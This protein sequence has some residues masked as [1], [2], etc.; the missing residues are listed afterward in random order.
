M[1]QSLPLSIK[2]MRLLHSM[3]KWPIT[4]IGHSIRACN[5]IRLH[6]QVLMDYTDMATK[7]PKGI[8]YDQAILSRSRT[9]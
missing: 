1:Q 7:P 3:A 5:N 9:C 6:W 4:L 8:D 2:S